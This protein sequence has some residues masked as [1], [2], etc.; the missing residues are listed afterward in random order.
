MATKKAESHDHVNEIPKGIKLKKYYLNLVDEKGNFEQME[1]Q[2]SP[3]GLYKTATPKA[4]RG[5]PTLGCLLGLHAWW[6][7]VCLNCGKKQ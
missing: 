6:D 5:G 7:G 3:D 4:L 2:A 1:I